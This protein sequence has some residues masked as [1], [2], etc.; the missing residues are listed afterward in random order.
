MA[1]LDFFA[2]EAD[3]RDVFDFLF[4]STDVRVFESCSD[5]DQELREFRSFEELARVFPIGIDQVGSGS[6]ILLQ[7]WSPSVMSDLAVTRIAVKSKSRNGHTFRHRIDG[8]GLMQLYLGGVHE[9]VLTRSHLGADPLDRP[10]TLSPLDAVPR[11]T[12]APSVMVG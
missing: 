8:G 9:R 4:S 6:A 12:F 1:R 5:F 3:Q 7:L 2:A 11:K 10:L